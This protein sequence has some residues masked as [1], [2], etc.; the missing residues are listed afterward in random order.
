M[1]WCHASPTP[2]L[3]TSQSVHTAG[4]STS[5]LWVESVTPG[6]TAR[7]TTASSSQTWLPK[8]TRTAAHSLRWDAKQVLKSWV[9]MTEVPRRVILG[10][11]LFWCW[12][13]FVLH[14]TCPAKTPSTS[15]TTPS[16]P[17]TRRSQSETSRSTTPSAAC[18]EQPTWWTTPS[19]AKGKHQ[20]GGTRRRQ[21][22]R[23]SCVHSN[24]MTCSVFTKPSAFSRVATVYVNNG[25]LGTFR[26]QLSMNVFTVSRRSQ[27]QF[28][29]WKTCLMLSLMCY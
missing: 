29:Q 23:G 20:S 26:S 9:T 19:S 16:C 4:R 10:K 17:T 11:S 25:S 21:L 1:L 14:S 7:A 3:P 15:S 5:C 13:S 28:L 18:T 6:F 8:T 27:I 24:P 22:P 12:L 2:S